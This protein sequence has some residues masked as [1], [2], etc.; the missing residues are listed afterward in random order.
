[1]Q[2]HIHFSLKNSTSVGYS[3]IKCD[4]MSAFLLVCVTLPSANAPNSILA[5]QVA[6]WCKIK[7]TAVMEASKQTGSEITHSIQ[8]KKKKKKHWHL[9]KKLYEQRQIKMCINQLIN[10]QCKACQSLLSVIGMA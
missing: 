8:P 5:P 9:Y 7:H 3:N 4:R 2:V 10:V 1:M 6:I